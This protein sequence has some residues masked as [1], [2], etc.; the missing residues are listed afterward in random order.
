M[1]RTSS[2]SHRWL[3]MEGN[4]SGPVA[5][6]ATL[7]DAT[8]V[9]CNH[10]SSTDGSGPV[11]KPK[12]HLPISALWEIGLPPE[13]TSVLNPTT[14]KMMRE[15]LAWPSSTTM[16]LN[17]TMLL[18]TTRNPSSAKTASPCSST[19]VLA[20]LNSRFKQSNSQFLF[21]LHVKIIFFKPYCH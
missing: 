6:N 16:V 17:G 18:A 13:V 2:S 11:P 5:V 14:V 7:T 9:I 20:E 15:N 8:A 4:T 10:S 19:P 3:A 1:G 12:S 21:F